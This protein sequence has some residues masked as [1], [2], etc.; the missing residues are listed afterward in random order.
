MNARRCSALQTDLPQPLCA[1]MSPDAVGVIARD[2]VA[3]E[4]EDHEEENDR[5]ELDTG[6]GVK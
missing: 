1:A 2:A 4:G 3:A 6:E 5:G